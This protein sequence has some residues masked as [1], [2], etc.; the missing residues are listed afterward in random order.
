MAGVLRLGRLR[1]RPRLGRVG[2][3]DLLLMLLL[4]LQQLL[5]LLLKQLPVILLVLLDELLS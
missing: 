4:L 2:C 3:L 1:G 5:A